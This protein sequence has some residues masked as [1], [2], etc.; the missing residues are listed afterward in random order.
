VDPQSLYAQLGQLIETMPDLDQYGPIPPET[1]RWLGRAHVLVTATGDTV[2]AAGL[3]AAADMLAISRE[4]SAASIRAIVYRALA[5]AEARAPASAQGAFIPAGNAFDAMT[6]VGKVLAS[7]KRDALIVDP[8]MDEKALTDFAPLAHEGVSIRLLADQKDHKSTLK[9]AVGRWISQFGRKRPIEARLALPKTLH[10][11]LIIVDD[12]DAWILTQSLNAFAARSPASI[13]RASS[14]I[15]TLK[16][17]A[18]STIWK[19]ASAL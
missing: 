5:S 2:D 13:S 7:A 8:Y 11:R 14:D 12:T 1:L 3:K 19:N 18:Y 17:D 4:L 16:V 9:P 6:A 15:A 10:D